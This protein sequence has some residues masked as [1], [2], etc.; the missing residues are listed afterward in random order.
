MRAASKARSFEPARRT[1]YWRDDEHSRQELFALAGGDPLP[2]RRLCRAASGQLRALR[3]HRQ[4]DPDRRA[5]VLERRPPGAVCRR[6]GGLSG[7]SARQLA[8]T[9]SMTDAGGVRPL[10]VI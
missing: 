3:R 4:A 2:R 10:L 1:L 7:V 8:L 6:G 9:A 5:D